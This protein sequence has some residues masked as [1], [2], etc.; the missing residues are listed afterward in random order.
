MHDYRRSGDIGEH[1][2]EINGGNGWE[3]FE[4]IRSFSSRF[5]G[6]KINKA[7]SYLHDDDVYACIVPRF[8][9]L[10]VEPYLMRLLRPR[11]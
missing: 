6:T 7:V 11:F 5:L 9:S 2:D 1:V 8:S 3:V 10:S 4:V